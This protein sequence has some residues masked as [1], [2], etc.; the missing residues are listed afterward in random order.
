MG[1]ELEAGYF[2]RTV[3][4]T[5]DDSEGLRCLLTELGMQVLSGVA[6]PMFVWI[7]ARHIES[8]DYVE[9]FIAKVFGMSQQSSGWPVCSAN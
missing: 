8:R 1:S 7:V 5:Y 6:L 9:P 2:G 4:G 3:G